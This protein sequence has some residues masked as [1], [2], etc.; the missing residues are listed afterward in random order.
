M[1]SFVKSLALGA[2]L[3]AA[4]IRAYASP[5]TGTLTIDGGYGAITPAVLNATTTS[6]SPGG[7]IVALGG[8]G[9]LATVPVLEYVAFATNFTFSVGGP[10]LLGEELLAFVNQGVAEAFDVDSVAIA[11]NGSLTFY[12]VLT[13]GNPA[14]NSGAFYV[15][16]PNV[17][18]DGSFSGT[19]EIP[20][21][22]E[23]DSLYLMGT[24]LVMLTGVLWRRRRETTRD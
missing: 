21:A 24:G 6:I 22:P 18:G 7:I 8:S 5:I 10:S 9:G 17:S 4:S 1:N 15:L 13:D 2:I 23:P 16:T 11:S 19:L 14:D 3:A 12:G 20:H